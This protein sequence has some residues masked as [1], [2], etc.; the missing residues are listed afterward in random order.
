[1][2]S[3][4]LFCVCDYCAASPPQKLIALPIIDDANDDDDEGEG[5]PANLRMIGR[6]FCIIL[7]SSSFFGEVVVVRCPF[8][9]GSRR[10]PN[11]P[12]FA[13]L[14]HRPPLIGAAAKMPSPICT[15]A[16]TNAHTHI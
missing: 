11:S 8:I 6:P 13:P 16:N 10:P 7:F 15:A 3:F 2:P 1:M 9:G 14:I 12:L 4:H 5:A